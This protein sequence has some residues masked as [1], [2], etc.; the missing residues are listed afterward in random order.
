MCKFRKAQD[1]ILKSSFVRNSNGRLLNYLLEFSDKRHSTQDTFG[2]CWYVQM[3]VILEYNP[4]L[5]FISNISPLNC[6]KGNPVSV[7]S[8]SITYVI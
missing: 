3:R 6:K 1:M 4:I 8:G 2:H 7:S 5:S